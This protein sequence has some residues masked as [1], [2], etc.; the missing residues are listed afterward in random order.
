MDDYSHNLRLYFKNRQD[1]AQMQLDL[2]DWRI[3]SELQ[4]NARLS[5]QDLSDKVALSPS[6]CLRRVKALEEHKLIIGYHATLNAEKLGFALDAIV[7]ISL[8]Q[9]K[10]D[11]HDEFMEQI[12][13][14][15][16]IIAAYIVTGEFNYIL[17]IRHQ[18]FAD[19]SDFIIQ[20]LN[21]ISGMRNIYSHIVMA[22]IKEQGQVLS[23]NCLSGVNLDI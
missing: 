13:R 1:R 17:H 18:S 5:N 19:F 14:F 16:E 11:W 10:D 9:S 4:Q 23:L 22:K 7:Q 20:K 6:A 12:Q 15:P 3:L 8:D 21:K 2:I